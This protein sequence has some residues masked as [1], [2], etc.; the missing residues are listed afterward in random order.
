[1]FSYVIT[2]G[3]Y[4]ITLIFASLEHKL[5]FNKLLAHALPNYI[6]LLITNWHKHLTPIDITSFL[7]S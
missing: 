6:Y 1:M 5:I 4:A 3:N 7:N 2:S